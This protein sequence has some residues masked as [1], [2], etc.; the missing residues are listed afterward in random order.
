MKNP[1]LDRAIILALRIKDLREELNSSE[2]EFAHLMSPGV[3]SPAPVKPNESAVETE[4]PLKKRST[5]PQRNKIALIRLLKSAK[6]P[7]KLSS[8]VET[9]KLSRFVAKALVK[10]L[11]DSGEITRVSQGYYTL[12]K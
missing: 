8:I 12:G 6:D 11:G 7:V 9:L 2:E 5:G 1:R 3:K 4:L 10:N